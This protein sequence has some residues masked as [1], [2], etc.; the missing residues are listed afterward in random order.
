MT[1]KTYTYSE[2]FH[3]IQGE[4]MYA[5]VAT[6]WFRH[7]SC[8]LSCSG[9]GQK[10]PTDPSTYI[11][12]YEEFDVTTVKTVEELP[13]WKYGCDSSYSWAAKFKHLQ[14]RKT[15]VE[16]ATDIEASMINEYNPNGSFLHPYSKN[17]QHM[18]FTGGESLLPAAQRATIAI[19]TELK[20]R[21]NTPL[22]I[23]VETN[24][25]QVLLPEFV[26][27]FNYEL[28]DVEV[29]F[30]VSPKLFTVSGELNDKAIKPEVI[31]SYTES[32]W[33]SIGQLKPVVGD[34][35][36]MWVELDNV[37][38]EIVDYGADWP[39]YVMPVGATEEGQ[40]GEYGSH[41]SAAKVAELALARGYNVSARV[42]VYIW[43]N[44][45]GV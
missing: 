11:L 28:P 12:P 13:V 32:I 10:D 43:G 4:G 20:K 36:K 25:T 17:E 26:E 7:F 24:G 33:N 22:Y 41:G 6:A 37:I 45:I 23:T 44:T 14:H 29:L 42:H 1:E 40:A 27:F 35:D 31:A 30:S 5:G 8:N 18:C 34:S 9:F 21:N 39:V 16:I 19:L 38:R 2:I 3:S 15:A